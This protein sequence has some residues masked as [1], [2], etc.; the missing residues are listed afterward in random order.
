MENLEKTIPAMRI[1]KTNYDLIKEFAE[2]NSNGNISAEI[3]KMLKY[4][5]INRKDYIEKLP[6]ITKLM[7]IDKKHI[8][9]G[10]RYEKLKKQ[11]EKIEKELLTYEEYESEEIL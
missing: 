11:K 4:V 8:N 6:E 1:Y 3:R 9:K 10:K 5:D 2:Q 7:K